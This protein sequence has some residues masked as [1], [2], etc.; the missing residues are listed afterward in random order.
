MATC[1]AGSR[2]NGYRQK[3]L[4]SVG[5]LCHCDLLASS[6]RSAA[7]D[8]V[9]SESACSIGLPIISLPSSDARSA[10][11]RMLHDQPLLPSG[12]MDRRTCIVT[13]QRLEELRIRAK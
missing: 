3:A 4:A 12:Q 9:L 2:Y 5:L 7:A 1:N 13:D 6:K 11:V 8:T 10:F